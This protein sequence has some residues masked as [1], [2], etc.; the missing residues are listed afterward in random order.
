MAKKER[1]RKKKMKKNRKKSLGP[2]D[3]GF[4]QPKSP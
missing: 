4:D 1:K 3:Q 2:V